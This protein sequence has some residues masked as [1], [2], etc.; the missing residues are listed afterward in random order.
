M[1]RLLSKN[2]DLTCSQ[3]SPTFSVLKTVSS[4][5]RHVLYIRTLLRTL[6]AGIK[7]TNPLITNFF[8]LLRK[9]LGSFMQVSTVL[10]LQLS[11]LDYTSWGYCILLKE[12]L[13]FCKGAATKEKLVG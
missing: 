12:L 7:N 13:S 5:A 2:S 10:L 9:N 11:C 4:H 6:Q 3:E 1:I 8:S